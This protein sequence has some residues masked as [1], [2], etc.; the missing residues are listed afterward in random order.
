MSETSILLA[1]NGKISRE[2]LAMVPTPSA[3]A[4]HRP[5]PHHVIVEALVEIWVFFRST[6]TLEPVATVLGSGCVVLLVLW[7][8]RITPAWVRIAA[9][10]YAERLIGI[11]ETMTA[12]KPESKI[13]T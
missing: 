3:T 5:V 12:P 13:I 7:C 2:E 11:C 8:L 4:T 6:K 9:F 1:S 10:A